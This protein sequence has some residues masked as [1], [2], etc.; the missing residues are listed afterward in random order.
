[1]RI[2]LCISGQPRTWERC[3]RNWVDNI[4]P[5]VEKDVFFHLWD[6]NSLPSIINTIPGAPPNYNKK[7]SE[8]E[9][10]SIVNTLNPKKYKF[11]NKAIPNR[12]ND[13]SLL[14]NL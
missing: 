4:M 9:K 6:Y 7:I 10:E 14:M 2:A 13:P 12:S 5:G 1:M 11:D 3:Y 8:D